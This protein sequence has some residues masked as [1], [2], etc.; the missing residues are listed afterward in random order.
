MK[1][2]PVFSR[3][4]WII[5][6]LIS[7]WISETLAKED[8]SNELLMDAANSFAAGVS[9]NIKDLLYFAAAIDPI[10]TVEIRESKRKW[11]SRHKELAAWFL[12]KGKNVE[13][14]D[15]NS[16]VDK[17]NFSEFRKD[18]ANRNFLLLDRRKRLKFIRSITGYLEKFERDFPVSF[19]K[20]LATSAQS[21]GKKGNTEN[22][23]LFCTEV[24][25]SF[26][27]R[28]SLF[29]FRQRPMDRSYLFHRRLN[30]L[31]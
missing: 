3:L 9:K 24:E 11:G 23:P 7:F 26:E 8:R 15:C 29:Q 31:F 2:Q 28:H 14:E 21:H 22:L 1:P 16:E 18:M 12:K 10:S 4:K 5:C 25:L 19:I 27:I 30:N 20:V 6:I 17:A 13:Y